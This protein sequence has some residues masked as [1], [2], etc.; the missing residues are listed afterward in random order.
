LRYYATRDHDGKRVERTLTVGSV[1]KF[2]SESSVWAEI[3]RRRV[4]E[5]INDAWI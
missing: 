1:K 5:R 4:R 3:E 2:P